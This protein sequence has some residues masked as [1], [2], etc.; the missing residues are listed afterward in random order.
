MPPRPVVLLWTR[1]TGPGEGRTACRQKKSQKGKRKM[2]RRRRTTMTKERCPHQPLPL[3]ELV[4]REAQQQSRSAQSGQL[5]KGFPRSVRGK[6]RLLV[7][8]SPRRT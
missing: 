1:K 6:K 5:R 8:N 7:S 2:S 3:H 4:A